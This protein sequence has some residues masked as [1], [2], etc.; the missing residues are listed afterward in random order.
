MY[1]PGKEDFVDYA[2]YGEFTNVGTKDYKYII[3]DQEGLSAAVGEGIYPNTTSIRW[4]PEFKKALKEKRLEGSQWDFMHSPDLEA[5]FLKWATAS[6]PQGVKM[7]YT[8]LI[9]EKAGLIKHAIKCYYAIVVHFPGS[10]GWTY[11]HTP[12]YV[13]Q[14]AIAKINFLLRRNPQFGI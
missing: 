5:A 11:W 13:G 2:K 1:D 7:F 3:K 12:W 9:L 6:E 10:Y 4:D 14:A 8:G